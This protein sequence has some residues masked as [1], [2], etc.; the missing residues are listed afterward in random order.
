MRWRPVWA[1]SKTLSQKSKMKTMTKQNLAKTTTKQ[2]KKKEQK[3]E[4]NKR[5]NL[6]KDSKIDKLLG[7]GDQEGCSSRLAQAKSL[8]DPISIT[9]S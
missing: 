3:T 1:T 2:S 6:E 9:K 4:N 8:R 5:L 7:G